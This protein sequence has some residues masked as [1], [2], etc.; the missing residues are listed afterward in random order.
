[1]QPCQLPDWKSRATGDAVAEARRAQWVR[2]TKRKHALRQL[3]AATVLQR[4]ARGGQARRYVGRK[5]AVLGAAAVV[6]QRGYR[7]HLGRRFRKVLHTVHT[8]AASL[9][10]VC[11]ATAVEIYM[12]V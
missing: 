5:A 6:L 7:D 2:E 9:I 10:Q 4:W 8:L 11:T 1:M 3:E 12:L